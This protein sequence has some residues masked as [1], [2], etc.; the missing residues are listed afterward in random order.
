MIDELLIQDRRLTES[1]EKFLTLAEI[2]A[3]SIILFEGERVVFASRRF[4]EY[5]DIEPENIDKLTAFDVISHIHPDDRDLYSREMQAAL[6]Q[7]KPVYHRIQDAQPGSEK[8]EWLL[9]TIQPPPM[10]ITGRCLRRIV[11]ARNITK[12]VELRMNSE[13]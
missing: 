1:E 6:A 4:Y 2:A 12:Q 3:D 7:Q 11:Q 8:Y 10:M 13:D 9:K 5:V